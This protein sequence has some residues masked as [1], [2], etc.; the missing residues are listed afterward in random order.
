MDILNAWSTYEKYACKF[1]RI[2]FWNVEKKRIHQYQNF[3]LKNFWKELKQ[4]T[5]KLL[6][7]DWSEQKKKREKNQP[8]LIKLSTF[9]KFLEGEKIGNT[10]DIHADVKNKTHKNGDIDSGWVGKI[11]YLGP[12]LI[13]RDLNI[14]RESGSIT[15]ASTDKTRLILFHTNDARQ[16]N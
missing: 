11:E 16:S 13:P 3:H 8:C 6:S 2:L 9:K 12:W 4:T 1:A 5:I 15:A 14:A 10:N 7:I